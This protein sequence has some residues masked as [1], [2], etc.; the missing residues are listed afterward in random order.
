MI[1]VNTVQCTCYA[2][3]FDTPLPAAGVTTMEAVGE[4]MAVHFLMMGGGQSMV[5]DDRNKA[6]A[7]LTMEMLKTPGKV[8]EPLM[9]ASGVHARICAA[10]QNSF[11]ACPLF[12]RMVEES[13]SNRRGYCFA[14]IH[15]GGS[16][17]YLFLGDG[18]TGRGAAVA[19]AWDS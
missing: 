14:W 3:G 16:M 11:C 9:G 6:V 8:P 12:L 17:Q 7:R 19:R 13:E 15:S 18:P 4:F 10:W 2:K 5:E 1:C